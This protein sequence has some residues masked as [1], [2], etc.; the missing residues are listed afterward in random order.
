MVTF[1]GPIVVFFFSSFISAYLTISKVMPYSCFSS[2][3]AR[4]FMLCIYYFCRYHACSLRLSLRSTIL[5][6]VSFCF[7]ALN[8][9]WIFGYYFAMPVIVLLVYGVWRTET[10]GG[11]F[12]HKHCGLGRK[13]NTL[14]LLT[15]HTFIIYGR[16]ERRTEH[17]TKGPVSFLNSCGEFPFMHLTLTF[18]GLTLH[19]LFLFPFPFFS[20]LR[21]PCPLSFL[22]V[23]YL[24]LYFIARTKGSGCSESVLFFSFLFL[25]LACTNRCHSANGLLKMQ[26]YVQ[27]VLSMEM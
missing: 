1:A 2:S 26:D 19:L 11:V 14:L 10:S 24:I 3:H 13:T 20:L 22:F 9:L 16:V 25:V 5:L 6:H 27:S 15:T 4:R 23:L 17:L 21:F 7:T 18:F 12:P 8:T